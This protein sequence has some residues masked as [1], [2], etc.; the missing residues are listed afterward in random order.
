[1]YSVYQHKNKINEKS[2]IGI[3][4]RK[5]EERWG[6]NGEN[7]KSTPHFYAAI[8]KYGWDNFEHIILFRNLTKEEAC[9][10]EKELIKELDTQ[11]REKGYNI[12][13]DGTTP[14][15]A[16]EICE[17]I[18]QRMKRNKNGLNHPCSEE[19][20]KKISEAQ[21]GR[22]LTNE[23][24][25][26]LSEAAQKRHVPCSES[27]KRILSDSYPK[28]KKVLCVELNK[29]FN[30]VQETARELNLQAPNV[31]KAC[32]GIIRTTGGYHFEYYNDTINA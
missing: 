18:S 4:K 32:K 1:M 17:A 27:K 26:K 11:N 7:Y 9:E 6:T 3:T 8:K 15:M 2:Y 23:H 19:K 12:L 25:K 29:I 31:T 28:K 13:E 30:S 5:P 10:K 16:P 14:S 21:K 24:K 22:E 20:K